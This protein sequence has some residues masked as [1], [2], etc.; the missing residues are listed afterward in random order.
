M[1]TTEQSQ[2]IAELLTD[3][4]K[5]QAKRKAD[6][7]KAFEKALVDDGELMEAFVT[8][9]EQV[10]AAERERDDT[11]EPESHWTAR[12]H[13]E[14]TEAQLEALDEQGLDILMDAPGLSPADIEL[15]AQ[16]T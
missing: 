2:E 9:V 8:L 16:T 1:S 10:A 15:I 6:R 12:L 14:W 11:E 7:A 13:P 3:I 4:G 5:A